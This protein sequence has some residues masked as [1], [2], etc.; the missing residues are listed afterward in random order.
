MES[1]HI[2][3]RLLVWSYSVICSLNTSMALFLISTPPLLFAFFAHFLKMLE[4][5]CLCLCPGL[6]FMKN[7][8]LLFIQQLFFLSEA[9]NRTSFASHLIY[10][11]CTLTIVLVTYYCKFSY[12]IICFL[13]TGWFLVILVFPRTSIVPDP[14]CGLDN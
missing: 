7:T 4:G 1:Y 3:W 13:N 10:Y 2:L 11:M 6:V 12:Q 14:L 8:V 5:H 9:Q